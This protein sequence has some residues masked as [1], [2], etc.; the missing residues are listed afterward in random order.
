MARRTNSTRNSRSPNSRCSSRSP[1]EAACQQ[2][3]TP[4]SAR[5]P[6]PRRPPTSP[7][8]PAS[9][10]R[11]HGPDRSLAATPSAAH[12]AAT[13]AL[14]QVHLAHTVELPAHSLP[15][16]PASSRWQ[17]TAGQAATPRPDSGWARRAR[18][19][20]LL[21]L[22]HCQT[23]SHS[24]R[25]SL[26]EDRLNACAFYHARPCLAGIF[27]QPRRHRGDRQQ[28]GQLHPGKCRHLA[29]N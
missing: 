12:T 21:A 29:I 9:R 16:A 24:T 1:S 19:P 10:R 23:P 4:A 27:Q 15:M 25:N 13:L 18:A 5:C 6:K 20:R 14:V 26:D 8:C 17:E 7:P 28:P 11:L 3:H 2:S 22:S